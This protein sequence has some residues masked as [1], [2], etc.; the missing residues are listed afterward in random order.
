MKLAI[1]NIAWSE[2]EDEMILPMLAR[3][4][5]SGVEVAPGQVSPVYLHGTLDPQAFRC[6]RA[7]L[8]AFE[9]VP[10]ALQG[11][12]AGLG[13]T[14]L[15]GTAA[16]AAPLVERVAL[17][18]RV[19]SILGVK[20]M[21]FG[22]PALRRDRSAWSLQDLD[23]AARALGRAASAAAGQGAFVA[24]EPNAA[25]YGCDFGRTLGECWHIAQHVSSPG[26][27]LHLDLATAWLEEVSVGA[28]IADYAG[29]V[30]HIHLS[31]P[32]LAPVALGDPAPHRAAAAA[33][34]ARQRAGR[35]NPLWLSIEMVR[36]KGVSTN[37]VAHLI[38][39]SAEA[40]RA[41]YRDVLE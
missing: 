3:I 31:E 37:E 24:L 27:G 29:I 11:I 40:V 20:P 32:H 19:A 2:E 33:L 5:I 13:P 36:P 30:R 16:E 26:L 35:R 1:S 38:Q 9:L 15:F 22:N 18:A 12:L 21:V 10:V 4:G 34:S 8:L 23:H 6:W 14:S 7:R 41:L 28:A 17:A 39:R 25:I